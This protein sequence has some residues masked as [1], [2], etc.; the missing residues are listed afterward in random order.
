[1]TTLIVT[2]INFDEPGSFRQRQR[3]MRAVA[4]M[5]DSASGSAMAEA[6]LGVE[7]LVL[8]RIDTDDGTPVEDALDQL[9]ARGF[10]EL[11]QAMMGE[12]AVPTQSAEN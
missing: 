10:D 8:E 2:P 1:M 11:M 6:Y 12:S 5:R 9:S 4:L 7:D 3:L